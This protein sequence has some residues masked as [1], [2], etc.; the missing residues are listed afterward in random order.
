MNTNSDDLVLHEPGDQD[1]RLSVDL[2]IVSAPTEGEQEQYSERCRPWISFKDS[3]VLEANTLGPTVRDTKRIVEAI[4]DRE[5]APLSVAGC[6]GSRL[7]A[8]TMLGSALATRR[9][10]MDSLETHLRA[11][12]GKRNLAGALEAHSS[13]ARN[14]A[15]HLVPATLLAVQSVPS[16]TWIINDP[17]EETTYWASDESLVADGVHLYSDLLFPLLRKGG[18]GFL[19]N[20]AIV[21][22]VL[23]ETIAYPSLPSGYGEDDWRTRANSAL[24][25][26]IELN[27]RSAFRDMN[28]QD[29]EVLLRIAQISRH[30]ENAVGPAMPGLAL[31]QAVSRVTAAEGQPIPGARLGAGAA[32][33]TIH[34]LETRSHQPTESARP[35]RADLADGWQELCDD[36]H[37]MLRKS[38][39]LNTALFANAASAATRQV[40]S[41]KSAMATENDY[42]AIL[43]RL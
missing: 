26:L 15:V 37:A 43:E 40:L 9:S 3:I 30:C 24:M 25:S 2:L 18:D 22:A 17:Q 31:T 34:R 4:N 33:E 32:R 7:M 12:K 39:H 8:G 41:Q 10:G 5:G 11:S 21:A 23:I 27:R 42:L 19:S 29:L 14:L 13:P 38:F 16:K 6:G 1:D 20:V 36:L 35:R 28:D